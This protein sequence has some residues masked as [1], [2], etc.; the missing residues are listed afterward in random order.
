[1]Y[2][3]VFLVAWVFMICAVSAQDVASD[4]PINPK[5]RWAVSGGYLMGGQFFSES[6]TYNSGFTAEMALYRPLN[7]TVNIGVGVGGSFLMRTEQF[8]PLFISFIGFTKPYQSSNYL[9]LNAGYAP[10]SARNYAQLPEYQ[11]SGGPMFKAGFGR[12]FLL[13]DHSLM[14][15]LALN[16]QWARGKYNNS[17]GGQFIERLNYDWLAVELRFFY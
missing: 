6:F 7:S 5:L 1:M 11:L 17:T 4:E 13:G 15:G 16:H 3:I 10:G 12:R 8:F 9:L 14:M 2:C